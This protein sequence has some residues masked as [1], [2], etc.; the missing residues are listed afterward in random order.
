MRHSFTTALLSLLFATSAFAAGFE[1]NENFLVFTPKELSDEDG[2][3]LARE[4]VNL[5]DKFRQAIAEE[6]LGEALPPGVGRTSISVSFDNEREDALTWVKDHPDRTLHKIYIR[7]T[8][9]HA[10]EAL[11][12]ML[13]HEIVHVVLATQYPYPK[14]LPPWL[15]EGVASRYDDADRKAIRQRTINWWRKTGNWPQLAKLLQDKRM[16]A[17][18]AESYTASASLVDYLLTLGDK[19]E[20]LNFAHEG[21]QTGW[22]EALQRHYRIQ[23]AGRL[24]SHWQSWAQSATQLTGR[25]GAERALAIR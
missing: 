1:Y 24:Q 8:P 18:Q 3:A 11:D 2:Q 15:E 22:D 23:D 19:A 10:L 12:D 16:G 4:V 20:L 13:G 14:R 7:A 9:G 6:W 17:D 5:A 21:Q 25:S